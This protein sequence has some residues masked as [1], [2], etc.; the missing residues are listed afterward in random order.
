MTKLLPIGS[1]VRLH[2][3]DIK[4]MIIS[5]Y[6]L[7]NNNGQIGYFDYSACIYPQGNTDNQAYFFNQEDI[8]EVFFE[9]YVDESEEEAQKLFAAEKDN[10]S[11]PRFTV[12]DSN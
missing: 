12:D 8:V 11:Y 6:P 1:V 3:G 5:R 9:G 2:N 7:Y 10:I 4:L